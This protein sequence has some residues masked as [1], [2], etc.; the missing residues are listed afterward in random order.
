MGSF[1]S[2][3]K[4]TTSATNNAQSGL[5]N[6]LDTVSSIVAPLK[7]FNS[8]ANGIAAVFGLYLY[9]LRD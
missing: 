2:M 4:N 3:V 5:N 8:I 6:T 7:A 1:S 9:P